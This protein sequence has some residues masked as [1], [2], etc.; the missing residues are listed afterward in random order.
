MWRGSVDL[1]GQLRTPCRFDQRANP[2][3]AVPS[4]SL[5]EAAEPVLAARSVERLFV[6]NLRLP[7]VSPDLVENRGVALTPVETRSV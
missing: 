2:L 7:H 5:R 6:V 3:R 4:R 1:R